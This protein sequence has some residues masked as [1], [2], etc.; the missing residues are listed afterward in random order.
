MMGEIEQNILVQL[1]FRYLN[2]NISIKELETLEVT[3]KLGDTFVHSLTKISSGKT[4]LWEGQKYFW[5]DIVKDVRKKILKE[6]ERMVLSLALIYMTYDVTI[7]FLASLDE[8]PFSASSLQRYFDKLIP[9]IFSIEYDGKTYT[10]KDFA[11]LLHNKTME[12]KRMAAIKG[13]QNSALK[14]EAVKDKNGKFMGS[15][16]RDASEYLSEVYEESLELRETSFIAS[17]SIPLM[18]NGFEKSEEHTIR[19][20]NK[21]LKEIVPVFYDTIYDQP[22]ETDIELD[23]NEQHIDAEKKYVR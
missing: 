18:G 13:G 17:S 16:K 21:V 23:E 3:K 11:D 10:G 22:F 15:K 2:T 1:V 5:K 19:Y 12:R 14:T 4:I 9:T 8:V 6:R 20:F 7:D